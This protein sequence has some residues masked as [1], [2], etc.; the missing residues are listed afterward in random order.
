MKVGYKINGKTVS[1]AEFMRDAKGLEGGAPMVQPSGNWPW[2]GEVSI[3]VAPEQAEEYNEFVRVKGLSGVHY[4]K[5]GVPTCETRRA[6][7]DLCKALRYIDRDGCY[8]DY[9]GR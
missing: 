6:R 1:R 2:R 8:G 4:G 9:T 5:D 3:R 7:H